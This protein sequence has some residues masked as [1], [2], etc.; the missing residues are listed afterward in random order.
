[1]QTAIGHSC[2][3]TKTADNVLTETCSN[4]CGHS[5]KATLTAENKTYTGSA[6]TDAAVISYDEDWQG[7]RKQPTAANYA[8]NTDAGTA[9][10][11]IT[12]E[13]NEL[14]EDF[15]ILPASL[16]K[17]QIALEYNSI[18]YDGQ[19]HKPK[20]TVTLDGFGTLTE[21]RDYKAVYLVA[22]ATQNGVL[23]TV[24]KMQNALNRVYTVLSFLAW[25]A[26]ILR[27]VNLSVC[28]RPTPLARMYLGQT[29]FCLHRRIFSL[30]TAAPSRPKS[31]PTARL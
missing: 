28:L 16:D 8:H 23:E 24:Q 30:M 4:G 17:A 1:M 12:V 25:R 10:V 11:S 29:I 5:A 27:Q 19:N 6:I 9:T 2:S 7:E 20:Y 18:S 15:S 3:Y 31:N 21:G 22:M 14:T 13:G 26:E